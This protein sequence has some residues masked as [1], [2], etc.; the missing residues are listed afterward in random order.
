MDTRF[1]C[2]RCKTSL[3]PGISS[4]DCSNCHKS[5][6]I[7][8][9]YVD[10]LGEVVDFYAGELSQNDM[11][12][13][14]KEIYSLGYNEG[15][16][17]LYLKRPYLKSYIEEKRRGDWIC[18][19][20]GSR[21]NNN[22]RRCLDIGSGLGNLSE[23]L[24]HYYEEVYS[25]E[26][27]RERIEFQKWR[28]KNSNVNNVTIVRGNAIELPFPDNYF[29]LVVCNGVLEWVGIMNTD[30]PPREVQLSFLQEVKRILSDKGCLYIGIEN[31][32][33]LGYML[34]EPDH[35]GLRYTSLVPRSVANLL[36]KRYGRSGGMYRDTSNKENKKEWRGY[37]TYT[38]SIKGYNS[39]LRE[40]GF[41]FKSYWT[42][43]S[44]NDPHFSARLDD[45]VALKG[46][47]QYFG[48]R[49]VQYFG[50]RT[51]RS[52]RLFS[53]M[54]KFDSRLL[55]LIAKAMVPCFLFYCYKN[56]I[57]ESIDDIITDAAQL[58][59]YFTH[60]DAHNIRYFLYDRD[61]GTPS[62]VAQV[63][64]YSNEIPQAIPSYN[65]EEPSAKQPQ[66]RIWF[67]DWVPD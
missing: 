48:P 60:G 18:H 47:V 55:L 19:C 49:F 30:R 21:N 31:R 23:M 34:G 52:K 51:R 63:R 41:K 2:P 32:L 16:R 24:S 9:Q 20:F 4:Y 8:D 27:V 1:S 26:A 3:N 15:L 17:R 14:I 46:F 39:L 33:G 54:E 66:E 22:N 61:G 36:V 7:R 67:E 13:L 50:S 6:P 62:K 5:Y 29:D 42:F 11:R 44:Y 35:S 58:T 57:Q 59:S 10:F 64:R 28:F 43:P 45:R 12:E 25:L 56:E 65:K 53:I 40:A 37:R 38:Y